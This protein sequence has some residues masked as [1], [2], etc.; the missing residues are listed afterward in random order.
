MWNPVRKDVWGVEK[1][2]E[3]CG[4]VYGASGEV[5][6]TNW[7]R[8]RAV[9]KCVRVWGPDTLPHTLPH[10]SSLPSSFPTSPPHPNTRSYTSS[11]TSS[12][13][14]FPP[15]TPQHIFLLSS[16]LPSPFQ[17]VAKIPRDEVTVAKLPCGEVTGNQLD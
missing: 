5:W 4:R 3:G 14:C 1:C 17:S 9:G 11:H 6:G 10:I 16:H 13:I 15:S 2:G 7:E 8:C 12:F